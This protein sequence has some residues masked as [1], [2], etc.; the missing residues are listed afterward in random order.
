MKPFTAWIRRF[1]LPGIVVLATALGVVSNLHGAESMDEQQLIQIL[2]SEASLQKKDAACAQ[3]KRVGTERCIPALAALL[4][5]EHLSH[6]ARYALEPM[7]SPNAGAALTRA[8]DTAT[9]PARV[10]IINS[11]G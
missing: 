3:L 9:C 6:S 5:D 1:L 4:T 8:I 2:Q 7:Q 10:G 11:L